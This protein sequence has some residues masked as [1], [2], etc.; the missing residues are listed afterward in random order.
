MIKTLLLLILM[1]V[2]NVAIAQ[3]TESKV[4]ILRDTAFVGNG[5]IMKLY[6]TVNGEIQEPPLLRG[7]SLTIT[8]P[9]DST[10][11]L[12]CKIQLHRKNFLGALLIGP[13]G[14]IEDGKGCGLTFVA[15]EERHMIHASTRAEPFKQ[16]F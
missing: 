2:G 7:E 12:G 14:S 3:D 1:G 13:T 9:R 16:I 10:V 5:N 4:T 15:T 8:V 6:I 11:V